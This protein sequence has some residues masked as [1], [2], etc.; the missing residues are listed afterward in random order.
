MHGTIHGR[1]AII[2]VLDWIGTLV[3]VLSGALLASGKNSICSVFCFLSFVVAVAGSMMHD[4][5]IGAV[6]PVAI[7]EF[8]YFLVSQGCF[9]AAPDVAFRCRWS[10]A[11]RGHRGAQKAIEHGINR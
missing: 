1:A 5:V 4:V 2:A 7:T 8:H 10:W 6:R 9:P 11:V 3:L